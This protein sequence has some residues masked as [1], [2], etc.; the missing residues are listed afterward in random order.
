MNTV[1][2]VCLIPDKEGEAFL[3]SIIISLAQKYSTYPFIPHLTIYGATP[4]SKEKIN[5]AVDVALK[6]IKPFI[7]KVNRLNYSDDFKKT[8]FIEFEMNKS[9]QKIHST[10]RSKLK[11]YKDYLLN[12]HLSLIYKHNLPD[13][14]KIKIINSLEMKKEFTFGR[15]AIISATRS[16]IEETDVTD[17]Q[18]VYEKILST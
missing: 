7:V 15:C 6:N 13:E 3:D 8:L 4:A 18:T 5:K 11:S 9:L 17:W 2:S 14:E 12:P 16:L 1:Y 10:L